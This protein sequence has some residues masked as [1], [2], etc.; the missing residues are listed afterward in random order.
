MSGRHP[1][2]FALARAAERLTGELVALLEADGWPRLTRSHLAVLDAL[3][4]A[5]SHPAQLA[6]ERGM[7]R[8]S[9]QQLLATLERAGL[10]RIGP[11]DDDRRSKTIQL[12][13]RGR[14]MVADV[15][16]HTRGLERD[17]ARRIGRD[18]LEAL[19]TALG[20]LDHR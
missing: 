15:R 7:T 17:V 2:P 3:P 13:D 18:G 12:T 19:H 20:G 11:C 6:R 14:A 8:Q 16:R 5:G 9:M 1:L 10:V 4:G